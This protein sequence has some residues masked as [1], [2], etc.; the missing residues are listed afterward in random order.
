MCYVTHSDVLRDSFRCVTWLIQM[1]DMTH[2]DGWH[3]SFRWVTWLIQMCDM[4]HSDVWHDSFRCV[5]WLIPMCDMTHSNVW[6]DSFRYVT[7]LIHMCDMPH[8]RAWHDSSTSL[9]QLVHA[10]A[11]YPYARLVLPICKTWL[12]YTN[13]W[14]DSF[15][16]V[17]RL[18]HMC[19]TTHPCARHDSF[20]CATNMVPP[21]IPPQRKTKPNK[22]Y[23][24]ERFRHS[25]HCPPPPA[26]YTTPTHTNLRKG[27]LQTLKR[28]TKEHQTQNSK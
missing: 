2:S 3:D 15:I 1:C 11:M 28:N 22:T 4:T 9:M 13:V 14:H 27:T 26:T 17:P 10:E 5:T 8:P 18:I 12:L 7:R 20:T 25:E 6:H 16:C 21:N 24:R 23:A 19:D